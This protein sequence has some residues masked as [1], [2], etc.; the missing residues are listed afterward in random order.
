MKCAHKDCKKTIPLSFQM[1]CKCGLMY[2]RM[3]FNQ[4]GCEYDYKE[5]QKKKL[6]KELTKM[7]VEKM[8]KI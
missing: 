1:A 3:H 5:E 4:H 7:V 6:E 2:C 8:E